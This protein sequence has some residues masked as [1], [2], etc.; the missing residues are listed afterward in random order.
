MVIYLAQKDGGIQEYTTSLFLVDN[1]ALPEQFGVTGYDREVLAAY[2]H[3]SN[4]TKIDLSEEATEGTYL[5]SVNVGVV[6]SSTETTIIYVD[7]KPAFTRIPSNGLGVDGKVTITLR[8]ETNGT[9]LLGETLGKVSGIRVWNQASKKG[10]EDVYWNTNGAFASVTLEDAYV[11]AELVLD[12]AEDVIVSAE[13][14]ANLD[15]NQFKVKLGRNVIC[16]QLLLENGRLSS[17]YTFEVNLY[18]EAPEVEVSYAMQNAFGVTDYIYDEYYI[19]KIV[20]TEYQRTLAK[21]Y[22]FQVDRAFS[23]GGDISVYHAIHNGDTVNPE[24]AYVKVDPNGSTPIEAE[25]LYGYLGLEGT[26]A[27]YSRAEGY[28]IEKGVTEFFMVIDAVGNAYSYYPIINRD[29]SSGETLRDAYGDAIWNE[30]DWGIGLEEGCVPVMTCFTTVRNI[31][32]L[33]A[34]IVEPSEEYGYG[35]SYSIDFG[36]NYPKEVFEKISVTVDEKEEYFFEDVADTWKPVINSAGI[37]YYDG[38]SMS[39]EFP[40]DATKAEGEMITHTV[41]LKGYIGD[42]LAVDAEGNEAV[43]TFTVT[44]PNEKPAIVQDGTPEVGEA[45]ILANTYLFAENIMDEYECSFGLPVYANGIYTKG[46]VDIFGTYYELDIEITDM[47]AD[48]LVE[49]STTE[50]TADPV[51]IT[52]TSDGG[53]FT[54]SPN[55]ELPSVAEVTGVDTSELK[56]VMQDNGY[57]EVICT[58]DDGSFKTIVI[59]VENIH[60]DPIAPEIVWSYSEHA[61]DK[62]DNSYIGEVTATLI[63]KNG[64][65]LKDLETGLTP[66]VTFVPG[67]ET[68]YT[69]TNYVNIVGVVGEDVK[70]VLPITLKEPEEVIEDTYNPDVAVTGFAKFQ[71]QTL[72]LDGAFLYE[73][74]ARKE[75]LEDGNSFFANYE[76]IYGTDYIYDNVDDLLSQVAFAE[77]FIFTLEI[78]DENDVKTFIV[79]D[80]DAQAPDYSTGESDVI[81][82]VSIVGRTLQITAS[83][84][85]VLHLVDS[86]NN[87]TALY[88]NVTNLGDKAPAPTVTQTLTKDKDEVRVYLTNPNLAGVTD[89]AITNTGAQIETDATS[90]FYGMPYMSF[91]QNYKDGVTV[92]YSYMYGGQ[93]VEG[94]VVVYITE[95]DDR[96]PQVIK[97]QW[98]AN[99]GSNKYTNQNITAQFELS[100]SV[101]E[102]YPVDSEGNRILAP[103]GVTIV[104]LENRLTV[105]YEENAE[106]ICLKVTDAIRD[107]LTNTIELPAITTIDKTAA[108]LTKQTEFSSNHRKLYITITSDEAVT[109][110]DGSVGTTY[111]FTASKNEE[112]SVKVSD[113]AGNISTVTISVTQLITEDLT[114]ALSTGASDAT[115]ID[116]TTYQVDIGDTLYVKT[117]RASVVT[118]NGNTTGVSVREGVWTEIVIEEDAEGLYPTIQAV[119]AYGNRAMVQLLQIPIKDRVAPTILLNKNQVSASLEATAE[120]LDELLR[121]NYVASDNETVASNLVFRYEI[122]NVQVAGRYVVTY[123]VEDEAG[124]VAS[125][126]GWIRFYDGEEISVQVNG[127]KVERDETMIVSAGTQVITVTHNGEP[128]KVEWR[129]GLKSLGQMKNNAN[130]LTGYTE[131]IEKEM[132]LELTDA[133]YYTILITTQGRDTYRLVIYVEE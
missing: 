27:E 29:Y 8:A 76:V 121:N 72:L 122:P 107:S 67:G 81:E 75:S 53:I 105:I 91:T 46:F 83:T 41:V 120:E 28:T 26:R 21:S 58:Y 1:E 100:K 38:F 20:G 82:G 65:P 54:I 45:W 111:Q 94:S 114:L 112:Y 5:T 71:N 118:L 130:V 22:A 42:E 2:D 115:I 126:T 23:E 60:N 109:W 77:K 56:I 4:R 99:Y 96:I 24:W 84:E 64:S 68:T 90:S 14:L 133:G 89:L 103:E 33:D 85:F 66:S 10:S 62:T 128:Y 127:Q 117:N 93:L 104:F 92:F 36:E 51:E 11:Q 125:A 86:K 73:D 25:E 69:F 79:K 87:S 43:Q 124:N 9:V 3:D 35:S 98:S 108:Q 95:F 40:Y 30:D 47:P 110:P 49:I 131:E 63:D 88:F 102:V 19:R 7:G 123:Y 6:D 17:V 106:A 129:K 12:M 80:K 39:M 57:F 70:V 61:V 113:K 101:G 32:E 78:G 34:N 15:W 132:T 18:D 52:I 13:T 119:D 16:Y 55:T 37:V 31:G 59:H 50:M 48:P 97:T 74:E 116:P 44:A